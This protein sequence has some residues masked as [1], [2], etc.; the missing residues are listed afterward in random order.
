MKI[1]FGAKAAGWVGQNLSVHMTFGREKNRDE[2]DPKTILHF[3]FQELCT[4]SYR[5]QFHLTAKLWSLTVKCKTYI[6][7]KPKS[8]LVFRICRKN[9]FCT[10]K[11]FLINRIGSNLDWLF[12]YFMYRKETKLDIQKA[13]I[14]SN[15]FLQLQIWR[16]WSCQFGV[17]I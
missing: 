17:S 15:K 11:Y 12:S 7:H 3:Q 6:M 13:R 2:T 10:V 16:H 1:E 5:L 14:G 9:I 8:V 4:C